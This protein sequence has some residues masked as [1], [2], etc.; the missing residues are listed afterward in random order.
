MMN[1]LWE[2]LFKKDD[3]ALNI[4]NTLRQNKLFSRLTKRELSVV[5][6]LLHE[7]HYRSGEIIFRQGEIGIGMYIIIKGSVDIS[8]QDSDSDFP[9]GDPKST[10]ITKLRKND[11]FGE[12]SLI[13]EN[14]KRTAQ[15]SASE[16]S[17]L[18]GFFKPDLNAIF[19]SYPSIG[20]KVSLSLAEVLSKRL[21]STTE[22]IAQLRQEMKTL[23]KLQGPNEKSVQTNPS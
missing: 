13:E 23:A 12:L 14:D 20:I 6:G 2:N 17:V 4:T 7:R 15:A 3:L 11:F 8:L 9:N 19:Q 1:L 22:K 21:K 10:L 5:E 16:D 18:V